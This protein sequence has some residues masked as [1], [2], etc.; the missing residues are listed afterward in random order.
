MSID[1]QSSPQNSH[2]IA[3]NRGQVIRGRYYLERLI[4]SG[5]MGSVWMARDRR[6]GDYVA[7]KLLSRRMLDSEEARR[8]FIQ[9]S[10]AASQ[11]RSRFAVR[12]HDAGETDDEVPFIVMELLSGE[13]LEERLCRERQLT[14]QETVR[15]TVQIARA[16]THAHRRKIVH[17]DI[18]PGNIFLHCV[19]PFASD[20]AIAKVLD[21][22]V[23]KVTGCASPS[24]PSVA[25]AMLGTPQYM[26]PE[27]V[28]GL[29]DVDHRS[30]LYSLGMLAFTMLT[31]TVAFDAANLGDLAY[32]ICTEDVP[33]LRRLVPDLPATVEVWFKH[34]CARSPEHRFQSAYELAWSLHLAS[35]AE[36]PI[37]QHLEGP[38]RSVQSE[39]PMADFVE[40]ERQSELPTQRFLPQLED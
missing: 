23:A 32:K 39:R 20:L 17:R 36:G 13:T 25:G 2:D 3:G 35:G 33:D 11:I 14:L 19:P 12:V 1:P 10:V 22:G 29:A 8:R 4:A 27:Q 5:G 28:R 21:F 40:I 9:E 15:F 7:V 18:K 38:V 16:L 30:D 34:A 24:C 37:E 26:S 6:V 31:G